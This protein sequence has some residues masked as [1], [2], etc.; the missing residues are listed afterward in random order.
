[1]G[2]EAIWGLTGGLLGAIFGSWS[3]FVF[4][5]Y[6]EFERVERERLTSAFSLLWRAYA[7]SLERTEPG[8]REQSEAILR[9][10]CEGLDSIAL[11]CK[12][13]KN[14]RIAQSFYGHDGT[15]RPEHFLELRDQLRHLLYPHLDKAISRG[16]AE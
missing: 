15:T 7:A 4:S 8:K 16:E 12:L 10:A 11:G 1:M 9:D 3:S 13:R 5:R 14:R 2:S 6:L